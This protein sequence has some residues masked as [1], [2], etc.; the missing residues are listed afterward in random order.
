[1]LYL[2]YINSLAT[3]GRPSG[4]VVTLECYWCWSVSSNPAVVRLW[5]YLQKKTKNTDQVLRAPSVGKPNLTRVDQGRK[6]WK[7]LAIKKWKAQ[8][9]VGRGGGELA[10]WPR[11]W[12]TTRREREQ[13]GEDNKWDGKMGWKKKEGTSVPGSCLIIIWYD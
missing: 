11:I 5:V 10:M 1:M 13:K 3:A 7:L 12:V 4:L 8:T 9:V 2:A 6:S